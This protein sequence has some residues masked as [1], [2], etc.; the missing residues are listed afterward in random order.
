MN[1]IISW[2]INFIHLIFFFTPIIL[3][4]IPEV[5][6]RN[7]TSAIKIIAL[8]IILTPLHWEF[9]DNN[10]LL[11]LVS[12]KLG[13]YRN[14]THSPFTRDNLGPLYK[15]I[16]KLLGLDWSSEDDL[17]IMININWVINFIAIWY[18]LGY[19]VC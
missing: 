14:D 7:H 4:F 8:L 12:V 10:C 16:M 13:D 2:I 18:V 1:S 19:K 15:P 5:L 11:S 9:L 6:L 17:D 3:L